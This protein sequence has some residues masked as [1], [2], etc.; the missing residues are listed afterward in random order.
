M[1]EI[2]EVQQ[3]Y[4]GNRRMPGLVSD[5]PMQHA[6]I[7][8]IGAARTHGAMP[9]NMSQPGEF[10]CAGHVRATLRWREGERGCV[11]DDIVRTG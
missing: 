2:P 10:S 6:G 11:R 1:I 8:P 9:E 4:F 5:P 7:K 3:R